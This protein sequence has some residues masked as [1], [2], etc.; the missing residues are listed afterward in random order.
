MEPL[1]RYRF[2]V[3]VALGITL[4]SA[5]AAPTAPF[6]KPIS[7]FVAATAQEGGSSDET[8]SGKVKELWGR[9]SQPQKE[10]MIELIDRE[11]DA[12]LGGLRRVRGAVK[13]SRSAVDTALAAEQNSLG[14]LNSVGKLTEE[15]AA[16]VLTTTQPPTAPPVTTP[17]PTP[18]TTE[19][20]KGNSTS[21]A[22]C[23]TLPPQTVPPAPPTIAPA[24]FNNVESLVANVRNLEKVAAEEETASEDVSKKVKTLRG[25]VDKQIIAATQTKKKFME[26]ELADAG[27]EMKQS[28]NN[29]RDRLTDMQAAAAGDKLTRVSPE[30]VHNLSRQV[31]QWK[32]EQRTLKK[33]MKKY[34]EIRAT[35]AGSE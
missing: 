24:F 34:A 29:L 31:G 21:C 20:P 16:A 33:K 28:F 6:M 7:A 14:L 30:Y 32:K 22:P 25:L 1:G 11:M 35:N 17:P 15:L 23:P 4:V 10:E 13:D 3:L 19:A 5:S 12:Q 8:E 18:A 26:G 2:G 9:L 27:G